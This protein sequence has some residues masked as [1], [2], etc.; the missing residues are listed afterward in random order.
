MEVKQDAGGPE[1]SETGPARPTGSACSPSG[2]CAKV[3]VG[4]R[5]GR[6]VVVGTWHRLWK[7]SS[8]SILCSYDEFSDSSSRRKMLDTNT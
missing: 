5:W 4:G 7:T 8:T 6:K 3:C 1:S 2:S